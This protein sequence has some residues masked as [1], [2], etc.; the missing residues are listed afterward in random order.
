MEYVNGYYIIIAGPNP[1]FGGLK[2]TKSIFGR[3]SHARVGGRR[4]NASCFVF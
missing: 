3:S 2:K 4:R 1:I